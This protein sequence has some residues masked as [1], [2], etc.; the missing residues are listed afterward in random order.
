MIT[1]IQFFNEAAGGISFG[2]KL[3]C[4]A[5][6]VIA[7]NDLLDRK[8]AE[9]LLLAFIVIIIVS[10]FVYTAKKEEID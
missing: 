8:T 6:A 9:T 2:G 4:H 3:Y 1:A 10:I 7:F 5:P